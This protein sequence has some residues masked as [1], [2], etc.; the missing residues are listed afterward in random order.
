MYGTEDA[1]IRFRLALVN[2]QSFTVTIFEK[3]ACTKLL[4]GFCRWWKLSPSLIRRANSA[5]F[6]FSARLPIPKM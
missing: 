2:S 1:Y 3:L 4:N 5:S 6:F